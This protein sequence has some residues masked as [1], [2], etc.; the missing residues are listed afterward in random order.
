MLIA[1]KAADVIDLSWTWVL[2]PF[3]SAAVIVGIM[4]VALFMAACVEE[5]DK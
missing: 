2:A 5:G 1:L 3:I 4:L